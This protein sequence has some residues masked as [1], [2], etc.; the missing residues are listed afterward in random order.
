MRKDGLIVYVMSATKKK[1]NLIFI[2]RN[3]QKCDI[4]TKG[5]IKQ[6]E[7]YKMETELKAK[8]ILDYCITYLKGN[9]G[10]KMY[11]EMLKEIEFMIN[12]D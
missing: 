4:K 5:R 3:T 10:K 8:Q 9:I 6:K 1:I 12:T 2:N 11:N 7:G